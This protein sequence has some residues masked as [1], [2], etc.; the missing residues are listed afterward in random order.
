MAAQHGQWLGLWNQMLAVQVPA[1][2]LCSPITEGKSWSLPAS[3]SSLVE[4][5]QGPEHG[6]CG[7][8]SGS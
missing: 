3:A 8:G 7:T 6:A 1:L 2:P 4:G 5:K